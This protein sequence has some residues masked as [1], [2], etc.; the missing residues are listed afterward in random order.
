MATM[1]TISLENND[2]VFICLAVNEIRLDA[3]MAL[4]HGRPDKMTLAPMLL[5][6]TNALD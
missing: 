2:V 6:D 4:H 3:D 5:G 1:I